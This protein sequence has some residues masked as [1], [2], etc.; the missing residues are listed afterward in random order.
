MPEIVVLE[1]LLR[2]RL[3][4]FVVDELK[5]ACHRGGRAVQS[6]NDCVTAFRSYAIG[7]KCAK[8]VHTPAGEMVFVLCRDAARRMARR[9]A[10]D[11]FDR[12]AAMMYYAEPVE[13]LTGAIIVIPDALVTLQV[14][15][16]MHHAAQNLILH[17][18]Y[19]P[20][21]PLCL[22]SIVCAGNAALSCGVAKASEEAFTYFP[23]FL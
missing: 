23:L 4:S 17:A 16:V 15:S 7:D 5:L 20:L 6:L 14:A 2:E 11:G 18:G 22:H 19:R 3:P 1:V 10:I 9:I 21:R 12:V 8:R 13:D